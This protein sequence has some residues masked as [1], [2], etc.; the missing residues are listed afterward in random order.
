MITVHVF[1]GPTITEAGVRAVIPGAVC[2]PPVQHGDVLRLQA[3]P[4]DVV[5]IID[6]LWHQSPAVR[7]KEILHLLG[8][9]VRVAG[10][11]SMGAL[12][13][14]ELH[15]YGMDGIGAIYQAYL[16]GTLSADD[17]VA[18]A[19]AAGSGAAITVALVDARDAVWRAARDGALTRGQAARLTE[20]AG[21]LHYTERTWR[22]VSAAAGPGL[23]PASN[24]LSR[25]LDSQPAESGAKARDARQALRAVAAGLPAARG[26]PGTSQQPTIYL[27]SWLAGTRP[28]TAGSGVSLG[29]V[30][31]H[32]QLYSTGFPSRWRRHA[33][34]W[35]AGRPPGT[36]EPVIEDQALTCASRCGL[37]AA[38]MPAGRCSAWL[39]PAETG[40]LGPREQL[41]RILVRAV[42]ADGLALPWSGPDAAALLGPPG[43]SEQAAREAADL[44]RL[45]AATGPDRTCRNL[46]PEL[47]Y[48]H[49]SRCWQAPAGQLDA[50]ARDRGFPAA[51]AAASA[52]RHYYL[53]MEA[54]ALQLPSSPGVLPAGSASRPGLSTAFST[55]VVNWKT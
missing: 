12:R 3:A 32:Q 49:L 37:T 46:R 44:N 9:G 2:H 48:E 29:E 16:D 5:L 13:A 8:E 30:L 23:A 14:A 17:E 24:Q 51:A 27:R 7:H 42:A 38:A 54:G 35:I 22:A 53:L 34:A 47:L 45:I 21:R 31:S 1:A 41:L 28:A 43:P 33:L 40:T 55:P 11:A 4:G 19:Q 52:A 26:R 25:W 10:A 36:P 15:R 6:G 50:A 20:T 18:V 39:T